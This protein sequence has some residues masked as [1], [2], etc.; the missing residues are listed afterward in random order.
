VKKLRIG[1]FC[2]GVLLAGIAWA[3]SPQIPGAT[4]P[5]TVYVAGD[6]AQCD[7]DVRDAA[8]SRTA[9]LIPDGAMVLTLGDSV[10][11]LATKKY[12][13]SCYDQSIDRKQTKHCYFFYR[14]R[15]CLASLFK[16]T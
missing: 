12:L 3:D 4:I 15:K 16:K 1:L 2:F 6:I 8:A 11:P 10:Y 5:T 13:Q 14:L 9:K 7:H